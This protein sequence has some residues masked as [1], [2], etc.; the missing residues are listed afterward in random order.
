MITPTVIIL[1]VLLFRDGTSH[2]VK[3]TSGSLVVSGCGCRYGNSAQ[4]FA[5]LHFPSLHA[6]AAPHGGI[7]TLADTT[8][9]GSFFSVCFRCPVVWS[10]S[11]VL[12]GTRQRPPDWKSG[13]S[14]GCSRILHLYWFLRILNFFSGAYL[15]TLS[16]LNKPHLQEIANSISANLNPL[17]NQILDI[18]TQRYL[19]D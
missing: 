11:L 19:F 3:A 17:P 13:A 5:A 18:R 4:C 6:E 1:L 15:L 12:R 8:P 9:S 10:F 2:P 16:I 7:F 14:G